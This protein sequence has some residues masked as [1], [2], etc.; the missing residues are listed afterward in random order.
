MQLRAHLSEVCFCTVN[1]ETLM[2]ESRHQLPLRDCAKC[3]R[4]TPKS[5][6]YL[7]DWAFGLSAELC[8]EET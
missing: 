2:S 5:R 4:F 1:I 8:Q 7:A 3:F 6:L